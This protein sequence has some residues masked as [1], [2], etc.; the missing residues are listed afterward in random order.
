[1]SLIVEEKGKI[2][3]KIK[4]T[5]SDEFWLGFLYYYTRFMEGMVPFP[6]VS[7]H[8]CNRPHVRESSPDPQRQTSR[9]YLQLPRKVGFT[10]IPVIGNSVQMFFSPIIMV[11]IPKWIRCPP[12]VMRGLWWHWFTLTLIAYVQYEPL[13]KRAYEKI[14]SLIGYLP[15]CASGTYHQSQFAN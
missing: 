5:W 9:W 6:L 13:V 14:H 12:S 2:D 3:H 4:L 7:P 11:G 8:L 10:A 15:L 1:M